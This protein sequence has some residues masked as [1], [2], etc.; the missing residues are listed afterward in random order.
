MSLIESSIFRQALFVR[1]SNV[2]IFIIYSFIF[3]YR[4]ID[5]ES[6]VK[7]IYT[8]QRKICLGLISNIFCSFAIVF[9][10][11]EVELDI[12]SLVSISENG[13]LCSVLRST[14]TSPDQLTGKW[15]D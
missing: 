14:P 11:S 8:I 7:L 13:T 10:V 12:R 5:F 4:F 9:S 15:T 1:F 3:F 2:H 6:I